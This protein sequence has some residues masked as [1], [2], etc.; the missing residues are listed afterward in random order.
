MARWFVA[1]APWRRLVQPAA[2]PARENQ[3]FVWA[4]DLL[5][6]DGED[7]R[8]LPLEQRKAS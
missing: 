1:D 2:R 6:L 5:A 7:L 8:D 4:F 3:G